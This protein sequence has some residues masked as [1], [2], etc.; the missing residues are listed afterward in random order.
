M[1]HRD[2]QSQHD[3][4]ESPL[5]FVQCSY[6]LRVTRRVVPKTRGLSA[7]SPRVFLYIPRVLRESGGFFPR[8]GRV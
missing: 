8:D 5:A 4:K 6:R 1:L 2:T 7:K 3:G